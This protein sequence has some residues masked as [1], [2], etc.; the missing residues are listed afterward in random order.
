MTNPFSYTIEFKAR[1][2][3]GRWEVYCIKTYPDIKV[4]QRVTFV[5]HK[6]KADNLV[7]QLTEETQDIVRKLAHQLCG[8]IKDTP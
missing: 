7:K 4:E 1:E 8:T 3:P 5:E 6:G 2:H